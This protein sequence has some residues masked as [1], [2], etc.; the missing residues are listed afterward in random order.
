[1]KDVGLNL[2]QNLITYLI[3]FQF[4]LHIYLCPPIP[5]FI[6]SFRNSYG[7]TCAIYDGR[8]MNSAGTAEPDMSGFSVVEMVSYNLI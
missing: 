1:M 4:V 6:L 2:F 8:K 7:N 5:S 3:H